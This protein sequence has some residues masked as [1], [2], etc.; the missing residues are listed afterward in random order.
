MT[1]AGIRGSPAK[2]T[3]AQV[4]SD[5]SPKAAKSRR[6]AASG[7]MLFNHIIREKYDKE[8]LSK[9]RK[10]HPEAEGDDYKAVVTSIWKE[11]K[12]SLKT[13]FNDT[14]GE[15]KA[16]KTPTSQKFQDWLADGMIDQDGE[17]I[18]GPEETLFKAL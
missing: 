7:W 6:R 13:K 18:N 16:P 14:A 2:L 9:L 8:E 11:M 1:K 4:K 5:G 15:E 12:D 10:A 3:A 17:E